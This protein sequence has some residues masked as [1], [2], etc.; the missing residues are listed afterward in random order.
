[1]LSL[2]LIERIIRTRKLYFFQSFVIFLS[3][4]IHIFDRLGSPKAFFPLNIRA[5]F[6]DVKLQKVTNV[7]GLSY[8]YPLSGDQCWGSEYLCTPDDEIFLNNI[9]FIEENNLNGGIKESP[10]FELHK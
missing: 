2:F 9:N 4:S 1:M 6:P 7:H 10:I 3:L 8:Y 5:G